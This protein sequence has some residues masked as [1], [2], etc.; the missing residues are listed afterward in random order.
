MTMTTRPSS[1]ERPACSASAGLHSIARLGP[2]GAP[3][4]TAA[5]I[6]MRQIDSVPARRGWGAAP[7]RG[8]P[9]TVFAVGL[10]PPGPL[11]RVVEDD[12]ERDP[13][14]AAHGGHAVAH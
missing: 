10:S 1:A 4:S 3:S 13:L 2:F 12:A 14:A 6:C 8:A 9:A 11:C 5:V 7:Y